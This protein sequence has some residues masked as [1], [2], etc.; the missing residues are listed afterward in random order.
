METGEKTLEI[1]N[2][3]DWYNNWLLMQVSKYL[4]GDILEVGAG[5]GNFTSKL[6]KYGKVTAIDYD[7]GYQNTSY[8]DIEKGKYF[9]DKDKKFDS[10]VCMNVLE[11]IKDDNKAL[12]NMHALLGDGG[13]LI[14]LVPAFACAYGTLDKELGHFRRYLKREVESKILNYKF[15]IINSRYLNW[16][17]LIGWFINGKILKRKLLPENQLGIFNII[18]RPFLIIEEFIRPIFGLSVLVIGEKK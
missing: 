14:L 3:A 5:N 16:L 10:I 15:S 4:K 11:H 18:A 8:G 12:K 13:R 1:M 2:K 9:F 17:G 7:S 6:S